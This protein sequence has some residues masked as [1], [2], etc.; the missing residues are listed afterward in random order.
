MSALIFG[1]DAAKRL[2]KII[3]RYERED[4][5]NLLAA[6]AEVRSIGQLENDV[7]I[8]DDDVVDCQSALTA[9]E[10]NLRETRLRLKNAKSLRDSYQPLPEPEM[11]IPDCQLRWKIE[12]AI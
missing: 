8:C 3:R 7:E 11:A 6:A 5:E 2:A 10:D 12:G 1:S 4:R 9:A